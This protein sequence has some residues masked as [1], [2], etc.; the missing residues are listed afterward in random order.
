MKRRIAVDSGPLV[1][2][3][4]KSDFDHRRAVEFF[5]RTQFEGLVTP[6]VVGEVAHLLSF[7]HLALLDFL[8][9]LERGALSVIEVQSD[10]ERIIELIEKY[11]DLPM[12]Y[13]D[14]T[15]VAACERLGIKEVISF[16]SD[17]F[18]YRLHGR[19]ILRNPFL[20]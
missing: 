17:F 16:D 11:S 4:D 3:F 18:I 5:A 15:V 6:A 14:A 10:L 1:A 19:L 9:W 20:T 2:L 7:H 12:D 8:K 13:S